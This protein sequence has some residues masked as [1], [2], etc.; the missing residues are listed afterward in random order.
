MLPW[1][2]DGA[3]H[4]SPKF[5]SKGNTGT[6][7]ATESEGKATQRLSHLGIHPTCRHQTQTLLWMSRSACW[8][9][10][11]IAVPWEDQPG[12]DQYRG[13]YSEAHSQPLDLALSKGVGVPNGGDRRRTEGAEWVLSGISGRGGPW[14]CE[15][16]MSQCRGMLGQWGRSG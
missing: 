8:Q 3:T 14:S 7:C 12:P 16:L 2:K 15:G 4:P 13:G 11:D 9:E 10:P 1:L 6:K 5:L